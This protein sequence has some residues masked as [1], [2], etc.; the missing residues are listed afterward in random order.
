MNS[1]HNDI[2]QI[3]NNISCEFMLQYV[4]FMNK[5]GKIL[6][7]DDSGHEFLSTIDLGL[8]YAQLQ[9]IKINTAI[10]NTTIILM[11]RSYNLRMVPTDLHPQMH[12]QTYNSNPNS[13]DDT[14]YIIVLQDQTLFSYLFQKIN[15]SKP[16]I[17][18]NFNK[19]FPQSELAK[20]LDSSSGGIFITNS[21]GNVIFANLAYESATGLARKNVIGKKISELGASG[22]LN[23][24]ITPAI[25][26][27]HENM[28]VLQKLGTGKYAVI[29]GS[30]IYDS[31]GNPILIITCVNVIT[32]MIA[33]ESPD[34]YN[35][36]STLEFNINK[37][38]KDHSIDIIAESQI[39]KTL[40]QEVIKLAR[41]NVTVLLLG[42]TGVG[43]EVIGSIIHAS[44]KRNMENF[45]KINCSAISPSLLESELFGYE[46]GSFTGALTKGKPGL[47]EIADKGTLLLDEIGDM[48]IE[49]QAKL[50]RVIQSHEFYRI[51]GVEP[52]K[53]NTRI[54]ASTN[55]DL[56][57]LI[58]K[59]EFREDLYYRLNVISI[60]IPPIRDRKED[61]KPLLLHFIYF[62]NKKYGTNKQFS[63]ELIK[64]LEDYHWPGNIRELQNIVERL[65]VLCIED[66]LLPEHL[67]SKY[68]FGSIS[69]PTDCDIQINRIMPLQDAISTVEKILVTKAMSLCKSTRKAAELLGVS[70]ST[71][72]RKLKDNNVNYTEDK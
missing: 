21:L 1:N 72:M 31:I 3:S 65:I 40:L 15:Q 30:P 23:P 22:V 14:E 62:Y 70:Q 49:L 69:A 18:F 7:C 55:K 63:N 61:I 47:F 5:E 19:G 33:V 46:A 59:G 38:K 64:V 66:L 41:Y 12:S 52:I 32:K 4:F 48:P 20:I 17:Y 50:L 67:Y 35:D 2:D 60:N 6:T 27:T 68:K 56:E 39:M 71:V 45:V 34:L 37:R 44:S 24:L 29:S 58:Q 9:S 57:K 26:E 43:K 25:L 10:T 28:T 8:F 13:M 53:S 42:E 11:N 16:D 54:I 36:S 51:G